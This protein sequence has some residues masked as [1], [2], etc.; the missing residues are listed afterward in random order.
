M[1]KK[2]IL[3]ALIVL[4]LFAGGLAAFD[5]HPGIERPR[6]AA[7]E[8]TAPSAAFPLTLI[9]GD[10]KYDVSIPR[11]AS[12]LDAMQTAR[13]QGLEFS[14]TEYPSLGFFVESLNGKASARGSY[15]FLYVNDAS[16]ETGASQTILKPGDTVEWRYEIS[17]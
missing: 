17:H 13:S 1:N 16:S 14:G 12:V 11:G 15:W 4:A 3:Y 8:A 2:Y 10:K 6:S 9:V 7:P 5:R